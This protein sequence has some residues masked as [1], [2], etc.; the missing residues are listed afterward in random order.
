MNMNLNAEFYLTVIFTEL[1]RVLFL[2]L[3]WP[4]GNSVSLSRPLVAI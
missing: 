1:I 2:F 3:S 4:G